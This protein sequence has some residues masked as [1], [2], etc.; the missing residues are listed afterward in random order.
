MIINPQEKKTMVDVLQTYI[1]HHCIFRCDPTVKYD[2]S[3]PKGEISPRGSRKKPYTWQFYLRRLTH[4]ARMMEYVALIFLD[5]LF[6]NIKSGKEYPSIQLVGL[7][8]SSIPIMIAMQQHAR[9]HGATINS[10][11]VRK[12][13]KEY[14]LFNYVD[15]IPNDAPVVIVDDIINSGWSVKHSYDVCR[16]ELKLIPAKTSYFIVDFNEKRTHNAW[17]GHQ[18]EVCSIFKRSQF[19]VTYDESKA[20]FPKDCEKVLGN[21]GKNVK[22]EI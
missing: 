12:D 18:I 19:D 3:S 2:Y 11:S 21:L 13:R 22:E 8:T 6:E 10:F 4:N 9:Y 1:D 7:E 16:Y 20:W 15:G 17:R 14:G 5:T